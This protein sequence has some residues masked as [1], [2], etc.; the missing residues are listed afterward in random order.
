MTYCR[1]Y[2]EY[3]LYFIRIREQFK[4]RKIDDFNFY[5]EIDARK[6]DIIS[7]IE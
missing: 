1:Y 7:Y 6:S 4:Y 5:N 3:D 2:I